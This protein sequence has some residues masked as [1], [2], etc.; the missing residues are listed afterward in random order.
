ML[1]CE[2]SGGVTEGGALSLYGPPIQPFILSHESLANGWRESLD[3]E[4]CTVHLKAKAGEMET[5]RGGL[6]ANLVACRVRVPPLIGTVVTRVLYTSMMRPPSARGGERRGGGGRRQTKERTEEH[7]GG[8][9]SRVH[10]PK[11]RNHCKL[12]S[13]YDDQ[14]KRVSLEDLPSANK[15]ATPP[16][17]LPLPKMTL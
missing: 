10:F 14:P 3:Y 13:V 12:W 5:P 15:A 2:E 7:R 11:Q 1:P 8:S 6:S 16:D 17:F 9:S 4:P